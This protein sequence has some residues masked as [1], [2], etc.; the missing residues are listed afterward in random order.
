[1]S[2]SVRSAEKDLENKPFL[3]GE[4]GHL[5][6]VESVGLTRKDETTENEGERRWYLT[7]ASVLVVS[8]ALLG[9]ILTQPLMT[10]RMEQNLK[11]EVVKIIKSLPP[12]QKIEIK[13]I[14]N[15]PQE[16]ATQTK[17]VTTKA[18]TLKRMGALA[19][20]GSLKKAA[21][22]KAVLI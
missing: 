6:L 22:R 20:L 11:Q 5:K 17:T 13:A 19:A 2:P 21:S 8:A 3:I 14:A 9:Y 18:E 10:P 15:A 12:K 16:T 7:L 4:L 1:M